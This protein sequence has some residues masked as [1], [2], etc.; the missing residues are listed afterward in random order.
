M[1]IPYMHLIT[2]GWL[3]LVQYVFQK[4]EFLYSFLLR[5]IQS[6]Q[7]YVSGSWLTTDYA[8][9]LINHFQ[10]FWSI[11]LEALVGCKGQNASDKV[12]VRL[13]SSAHTFPMLKKGCRSEY[14]RYLTLSLSLSLSLC[15]IQSTQTTKN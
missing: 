8:D 12:L 13:S 7:K 4:L 15:I 5:R 1:R 9:M 6:E 3:L 11:Y 2:F 14:T 10:E